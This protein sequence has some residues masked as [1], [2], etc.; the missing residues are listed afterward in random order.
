MVDEL[1]GHGPCQNEE[2]LRRIVLGS[3]ETIGA[4]AYREF[5][6]KG[7]GALAIN[8]MKVEPVSGGMLNVPMIYST[9]WPVL[10]IAQVVASYDP[11]LDIVCVA[12]FSEN[13]VACY[14]AATPPGMM[15]PRQSYEQINQ[16]GTEH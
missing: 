8:A 9:S 10:D 3:W 11:E 16:S 2:D 15:T 1:T 5:L 7:R 4:F 12:Q 14:L 13:H 6:D